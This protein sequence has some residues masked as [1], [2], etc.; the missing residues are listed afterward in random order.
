ML[1]SSWELS[2]FLVDGTIVS[3]TAPARP[4]PYLLPSIGT[5]SLPHLDTVT[6]CGNHSIDL[7]EQASK[8]GWSS[9]IWSAPAG[10]GL[11]RQEAGPPFTLFLANSWSP[12]NLPVDCARQIVKELAMPSGAQ[13]VFMPSLGKAEP[14]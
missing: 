7:G 4:C 9:A 14:A 11:S 6:F 3:A 10:T 5:C 1:L 8:P 13:P 2:N 12:L